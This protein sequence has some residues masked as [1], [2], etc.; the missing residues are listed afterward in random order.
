M[1]RRASRPASLTRRRT[2]SATAAVSLWHRED[3]PMR[4][5]AAR[6]GHTRTSLTWDTYSHVVPED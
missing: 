1:R 4:E 2:T 6:V 5:I 3:V